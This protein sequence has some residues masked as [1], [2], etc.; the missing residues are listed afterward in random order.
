M[1]NKKKI[2]DCICSEPILAYS[3]SEF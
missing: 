3:V 2:K 1:K